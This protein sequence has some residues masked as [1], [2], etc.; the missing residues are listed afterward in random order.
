MLEL[1]TGQHIPDSV[2]VWATKE[3]FVDSAEA[4]RRSERKAFARPVA[5]CLPVTRLS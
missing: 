4:V 5:S 3:E 2:S 1:A